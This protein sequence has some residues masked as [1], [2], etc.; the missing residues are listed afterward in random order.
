[1]VRIY[2]SLAITSLL[3]FAGIGYT[4]NTNNEIQ[5]IADET[6][7]SHWM[8]LEEAYEL[9]AP[10]Y[11]YFYPAGRCPNLQCIQPWMVEAQI[12]ETYGDTI[13][14]VYIP[15]EAD[16]ISGERLIS[17]PQSSDFQMTQML[18]SCLS[19]AEVTAYG[20][21]ITNPYGCLIQPG[22]TFSVVIDFET[23]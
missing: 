6:Q 1:M 14:F 11:I 12:R 3:F 8:T 5:A 23:L 7:E 9:D 22:T 2:L 16:L 18:F 4:K 15:V 20:F 13:N 21:A 17:L 10:F 19:R